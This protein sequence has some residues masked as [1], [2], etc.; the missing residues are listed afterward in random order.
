MWVLG[1][2]LWVV[3]RQASKRDC[4]IAVLPFL[5]L[6]LSSLYVRSLF[7][8]ILSPS[9][10]LTP[11]LLFFSQFIAI[12]EESSLSLDPTRVGGAQFGY[13][14]QGICSIRNGIESVGTGVSL[15]S[16]D[17]DVLLN[18]V[19]VPTEH[20][21]CEVCSHTELMSSG[22]ILTLILGLVISKFSWA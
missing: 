21:M 15:H 12:M 17:T 8:S 10:C 5:S 14:W 11:F 7:L 20:L 1:F 4:P 19:R 2:L 16:Q 3:A 18:N 13:S 22:P 6:I 9:S